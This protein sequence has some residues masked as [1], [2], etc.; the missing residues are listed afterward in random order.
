VENNQEIR[1]ERITDGFGREWTTAFAPTSQIAERQP[2]KVVPTTLLEIHPPGRLVG[3]TFQHRPLVFTRSATT[4]IGT[5]CFS[6][7]VIVAVRTW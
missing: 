2:V 5:P 6:C 7:Q 1:I 4:S 3:V